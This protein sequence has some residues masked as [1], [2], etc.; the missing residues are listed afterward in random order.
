MTEQ[1]AP[2][3]GRQDSRL[4]VL[5]AP[6]WR[7]GVAYQR[8]IAEALREEGVDVTFFRHYYKRVLPLS[9]LMRM[10]QREERC[11]LLHLH[12]P[13]AYYPRRGDR[14]DWFRLARF[15]VDLKLAAR[16]CPIV[17]TAHNLK[18]HNR[19]GEP[20]E[21]RNT[22]AV[23]RQ[24]RRIFAHSDAA[25]AEILRR[26]PVAP[27]KVC[28]VPHGDLSV[29]LGFR[30]SRA[31]ARME[32]RLPQD[33][34]VCLFFGALQPYKGAEEVL[35]HWRD[36]Q[37]PELL[38]VAGEPINLE[39]GRK[40]QALAAGSANVHLDLRWLDDAALRLWLSAADS[41][42]FNYRSIF[43]SGAACLARSYGVPVLLPRRLDTVDL[44][45]PHS[46]VY[47]FESFATDFGDALAAALQRGPDYAAA[48]EWR[49]YTAWP[50]IA[51]LTAN[52]YREAL[53]SGS[54]VRGVL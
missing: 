48:A 8:L 47:R 5:F 12:W 15:T 35:E 21:Q 4:K 14:F 44:Q 7:A 27:G 20:F 24:A 16:L 25:R 31:E 13:E 38:A 41:V 54:S 52:A 23:I 50:R 39:Y 51:Q 9:R 26:F 34:P 6:D 19:D 10:Q 2:S 46:L 29:P 40:I 30:C 22:T 3:H 36:A 43:T 28:T 45:E 49:A 42:V 11:D 53:S 17:L 33:A 1:G 32:L 18:A 37:R